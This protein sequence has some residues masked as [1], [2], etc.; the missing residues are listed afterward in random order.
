MSNKPA[1]MATSQFAHYGSAASLGLAEFHVNEL[2]MRQAGLPLTVDAARDRIAHIRRD[3]GLNVGFL[4][5][6][7][8]ANV[9][10]LTAALE[11]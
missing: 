4:D 10:D 8:G 3:K 6:D 1:R 5:K 11:V 7:L 9:S 2:D